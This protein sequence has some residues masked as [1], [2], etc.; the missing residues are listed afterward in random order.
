MLT[1]TLRE[2]DGMLFVV[3]E[4][5]LENTPKLHRFWWKVYEVRGDAW[6]AYRPEVGDT[7]RSQHDGWWHAS[8]EGVYT[9]GSVCFPQGLP[10]T[11][12]DEVDVP[13]PKVRKGIETRWYQG[14]W[15]KNSAKGWVLA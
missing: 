9:T 15:Q 4:S 2:R 12:I 11:H 5:P 10:A 8:R 13:C 6:N 1:G 3:Y 14:A 7:L